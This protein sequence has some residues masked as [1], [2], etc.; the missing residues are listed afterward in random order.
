LNDYG[1]NYFGVEDKVDLFNFEGNKIAF[2]GFCCYSTNPQGINKKGVNGFEYN[3][4]LKTLT[5]YH[6]QGY[7]N[8]MSVHAGQEHVN[9]PNPDH[10]QL[11]R[12]LSD[13]LPYIYYGHHPHVLQGI[14]S[15]KNSLHFY[16]LGNFCF[17]DVYTSKSSLPLVKM[18]DNN[19]RSAIVSVEYSNNKFF[20]YNLTPIFDANIS[21]GNEREHTLAL[22]EEYSCGLHLPNE[23]Y[24]V[25]R[26]S[27]LKEYLTSRKSLRNLN[28]Y[29]KRLNYSSFLQLYYAKVNAKKYY[30]SI[31]QYL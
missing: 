28:W 6:N 26:A 29:L 15:Y 7:N 5:Y 12:M 31:K 25:K 4:V 2:S 24:S 11:A 17:D 22:I 16:S 30:E 20:K 9:Y 19:K 3:T 14:E 27:M 8:I 1:I 23:E 21:E 13:K 10:I 18:S